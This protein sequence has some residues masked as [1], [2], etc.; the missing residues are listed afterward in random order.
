MAKEKNG[1]AGGISRRKFLK[2]M[3]GGVAGVATLPHTGLLAEETKKK[4]LG[5]EADTI[6]GSN[7][8]RLKIN[9]QMRSVEVEPRT[10]LLSALRENLEL[11]G[12]KEVCDRGQCG[13]CTVIIDG[14]AK[15]SCMTLALDARDKEITT[16]EGL[17]DGEELTALQSEFA[18]KDAL[19][20]GFC[21][22]GFVMAGTALLQQNPN[23]TMDEIKVGVSGNL[24]R[25]G[26]YPKVFEAIDAAAKT[27][28]KGG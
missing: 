26:T 15:L 18:E 25:C 12:A 20:C 1:A 8:I 13:A 6:S 5:A 23:P 28:K 17:A 16:V 14:K 4:I 21:T 10:T 19:M 2:G 3:G 7:T 9:K 22:P 27:M 24:C 11:T